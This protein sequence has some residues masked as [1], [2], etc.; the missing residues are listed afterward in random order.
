MFSRKLLILLALPALACGMM[1]VGQPTAD[2]TGQK[3]EFSL[4]TVSVE[5]P[6][7]IVTADQLHIRDEA[8]G[9][10]VG[11]L[12]AGDVVTVT[13]VLVVGDV[14]WCRHEAGWSACRYLEVVR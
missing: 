5:I 4:P 11:Y 3:P 8:N 14:F 13:D 6:Q 2:F 1:Q 10:V 7:Y 9:N 12:Y